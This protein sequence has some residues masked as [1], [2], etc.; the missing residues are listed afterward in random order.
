MLYP[1]EGGE[2]S[3][4]QARASK[5][6]QLP[7]SLNKSLLANW[8]LWHWHS[9]PLRLC[10]LWLPWP[11]LGMEQTPNFGQTVGCMVKHSKLAPNLVALFPK[12]V[13][14][15]RIVAEG[16]D[17]HRWVADIV[18]LKEPWQYSHWGISTGLG[19]VFSSHLTNH[20]FTISHTNQSPDL[21]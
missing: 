13:F 15:R 2:L 8:S 19:S 7:G 20:E 16:L 6:W 21:D 3:L 14:K 5:W 11:L 12:I 1:R 10:F 4:E 18:T 9:W 17:N